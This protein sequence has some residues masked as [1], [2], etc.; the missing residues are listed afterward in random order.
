MGGYRT[1]NSSF[2]ERTIMAAA[3]FSLFGTGSSFPLDYAQKW[4]EYIKPSLQVELDNSFGCTNGILDVDTR[5]I[6]H[7]IK[8]IRSILVIPM[9][10]LA[11]DIGVTRQALYKWL[12]GES[13]PEDKN[14]R[15]YIEALSNIADQFSNAGISNAKLLVK[16]KAF[17]GHSLLDIVKNN[18]EWH[19]NVNILIEES[20]KSES[21]GR[22]VNSIIKNS[23]P[24]E[25]WRS[26]ISIPRTTT[27]GN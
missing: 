22:K 6:S 21:A 14:N 18:G 16:M 2:K 25:G 23:I 10:E 13:Q 27:E 20:K 15:T 24:N 7:H 8:N 11:R 9:S 19:R 4:K 5:T 3:C 26:S 17:N 12:S 1:T